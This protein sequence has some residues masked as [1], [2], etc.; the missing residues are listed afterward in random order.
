MRN[1]GEL[2]ETNFDCHYKWVERSKNSIIDKCNLSVKEAVFRADRCKYNGYHVSSDVYISKNPFKGNSKLRIKGRE[3]DVFCLQNI[4]ID[5]DFHNIVNMGREY[6]LEFLACLENHFKNN[7]YPLWNFAQFTG[8][9]IQLWWNFKSVAVNLKWEYKLVVNGIIDALEG[10]VNDFDGEI[11]KSA[12]K[13]L[14][15]F[16]RAFGGRNLKSGYYTEI[17]NGSDNKYTL[18]Y[19]REIFNPK[20]QEWVNYKKDNEVKKELSKR[21]FRVN[22][23]AGRVNIIEQFVLEGFVSIGVRDYTIFHYINAAMNVYEN[24]R[25]KVYELNEHFEKPLKTSEIEAIIR[26]NS[27]IV[28]KFGT[29]GYACTNKKIIDDLGMTKE[30]CERNHFYEAWSGKGKNYI[31]DSKRAEKKEKFLQQI[32]SCFKE[33][34]TIFKTA[35]VLKISYNTAKKYYLLY[36]ESVKIKKITIIEKLRKVI[37]AAKQIK[38]KNTKAV[39]NTTKIINTK[40]YCSLIPCN[41][42]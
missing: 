31:R 19:L 3:S 38:F 37:K 28:N 29:K 7:Y 40:G 35:K 16:V 26:C 33:G 32:F 11:D 8:R 27:K 10:P 42:C 41:L 4:V 23:N 5:I 34:L 1:L 39:K 13:R 18:D 20:T 36:T 21:L 12:S 9:G 14:G 2:F 22:I 6:I 15:G 24:W 30:F 17:I 25:D